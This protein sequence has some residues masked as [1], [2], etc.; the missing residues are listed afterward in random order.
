MAIGRVAL[1]TNTN[2]IGNTAV[3]AGALVNSN[4]GDNNTAIGLAALQNIA[5]R[6]GNTAL[7]AFAGSLVT[8]ANNVICIG[9]A[10]DDVDNS[11]YIGNIYGAEISEFAAVV[12][13]D[14]DG[15]V[16]TGP[17]MPMETR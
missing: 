17:S 13:V 3:G 11:C 6:S 12:L 14:A 2:G 5:T 15:K 16:G 7:G 4:D 9:A 1:V 10:G 8:E